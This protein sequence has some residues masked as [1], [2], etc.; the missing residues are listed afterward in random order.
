MEFDEYVRSDIA[1]LTR[2]A[3]VLTGDSSAAHDVLADA[4]VT[5]ADRWE[6]IA[7]MQF[8]SAYVRR[9]VVTTFL[10]A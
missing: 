4:L 6:R 7:E 3:G 1:A 10:S 5:V 2:F 8:V 9:V